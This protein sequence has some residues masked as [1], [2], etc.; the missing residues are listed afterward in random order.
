MSYRLSQ[1]S[2]RTSTRGLMM[3]MAAT[4]AVGRRNRNS[5]DAQ[6]LRSWLE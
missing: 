2:P 3:T 4:R 1:L 6:F 5:P